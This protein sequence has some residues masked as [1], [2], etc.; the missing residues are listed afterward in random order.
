MGSGVTKNSEEKV[1]CA[2]GD[3]Q[4]ENINCFKD[5]KLFDMDGNFYIKIDREEYKLRSNVLRAFGYYN[6]FSRDVDFDNVK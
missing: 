6:N 1:T 2:K 3:T 5:K 4:I